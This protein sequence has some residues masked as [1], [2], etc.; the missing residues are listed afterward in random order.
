MKVMK[1]QLQGLTQVEVKRRID[2][3]K[4]NHFKAKTGSSN[5]EIFRRNVFNSFNVLNFAI[6]V[7]LIAVQAWSNLFFFGIIVLNAFTGMMTELRA[8]RMIDKLNLMNQDQIRVVR[9]G[10]LVSIDPKDIVLDDVMLLSA[11]EQVPSDAV[12]IDG[13]AELNEAMLTGESDH[14]LKKDGKE[15]LSGS[16]L[17]S[18]QVYAKVINVAEDNYANK[19]ML[20]AKTHK[21]I[22]SRIL[23]NMDKI[24]KFTGK[25]VIPFGLALFFEAY[26]IK[27]LSLQE[28]VVTSST[29]LLGM[30]PKGIALLTITSLL[31]AVIK[32]G[33]KHILVQEMYSVETLARVDVLCLDKTG[34]ITQGKMTVKGLELLSERFTKEEL[35]RLLAAYMQHSKDKNATAQ[36]IRNAY[37]GLEH[38][39]QVGDVIPFSSDRKWGAVS[40]N[41]LGTLFLGAPE[42][43]LKENPKAVD[44][45]QARG[46]RVLIL[47]WSQSGVD[48]ETMILPNDVE[49][50]TLLEIADPIREDAAETLEYL[51]S[52]DVT[53][54]IISGDNPVTVSH[55]AH[56]AGFA[57][58]QSYIDCSKVSDEELEALAE[59]TAIFGR[60]SPHQKKLLIQT[61]NAN[62]H[63]TAMTG[64]GVNDILALREA[65][66]SIVMAEGDPATRQ[67]ANLVLMDSEFKD[68]PEILFEGRRVVNNIAHIAPIFLI[69]TVYSFLLGLIC[70]ASIVF[71]K[72]EYLL[73]F[74]FIQVQMTL[75]GQFIEGFPPFIL[76]FERNIRP[77][78]KHFL[79]RSLQLS[80]PNALMLVISVLIFHLS[81]VYL[82]MSNTDMLTLSYYMMGS[83]GVLAVIRACIPLNKG[84]V[85]LII[86]SVFGFLIS[87]YYL[88]DVI[89]ISTLNSY[90]LPIY[91]VAMAICTPLFFWISYKQGAFQKA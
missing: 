91:L 18:G 71:G 51:R 34:T 43:L 25:I 45:A 11:G 87:S 2:A 60:V 55:I 33:M 40:V 8:R 13:M 28:S 35:E 38:H 57:D 59:D 44:Q 27:Q 7:A 63:T 86:Y 74:P 73:V 49:A 5:W 31:T 41:G 14:I 78:E 53:L 16:Y 29:A 10:Q 84:R 22:V 90:T 68:I 36:A 30:L 46:S 15:L 75:A 6:F 82:G 42:M 21:P 85:A 67:I 4:T 26:M 76:T 19:L 48:T 79:R 77:V 12:V 17:V 24:A 72:A 56:Q 70:I 1:K 50:L 89:A 39:Y 32:L 61:L 88:R 47:A 58:Y 69:K 37:E 65:D 83:T 20:E 81:Q 62:G 52:E 9:D 23:Y 66:C 64:D 3:G 80:I 54:K